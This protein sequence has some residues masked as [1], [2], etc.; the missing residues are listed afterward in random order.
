MNYPSALPIELLFVHHSRKRTALSYPFCVFLYILRGPVEISLGNDPVSYESSDL[1]FLPPGRQFDVVCGKTGRLLLLGISEDFFN[2]NIHINPLPVLSSQLS[3]EADFLPMKRSLLEIAEHFSGNENA[4]ADS[5]SQEEILKLRSDLFR[6]LSALSSLLPHSAESVSRSRDRYLDR[7]QEIADYID[8]HYAQSLTLPDLASAF[9]LTPQYLSAFFHEHFGMNFKTYVT[10]R[11]LHYAQ[12]DLRGSDTSISEIALK[13]GFASVSTFQKNFQKYCGCTPS[14]YRSMQLEKQS[15]RERLPALK[16]SED[17][18]LTPPG[19]SVNMRADQPPEEF[20]HVNCM[21]NVGTV[22]NLLSE[23]FRLHLGSFCASMNIRYVRITELLSNSF[24]PMVLPHREYY[25]HNADVALT[26]FYENNLIPF[27]ELTKLEERRS[28]TYRLRSEFNYILR[29]DRF[30]KLLESFLKHVSRRW[31]VSWLKEWKFEMYLLPRDSTVSYVD[32]FQRAARI[33][34]TYIPGAAVGGP[35][36]D[37]VAHTISA[38]DLL[39]EF[40]SRQFFP[41]FFSAT[42]HYHLR[43]ADGSIQISRNPELLME[44]C[45]QLKKTL[46]KYSASLPL[47]VTEWRSAEP[48]AA[49]I[50]ASRYQSAFIAKTWAALDEVC[51]LAGYSLF[52]DTEHIPGAQSPVIYQ[53]GRGLF[54]SGFV[55]YAAYHSYAMSAGLGVRVIAKGNCW[56][57][58]LPEE[59]HY[60]LLVWHYVHFQTSTDPAAYDMAYFDRV[61]QFF[62]EAEDLPFRAVLTGLRPGL[63]HILRTIIDEDHGSI[64]DV[65]IGEFRHSNIDRI[66]FL[67]N[68]RASS[69]TTGTHRAEIALPLERSSYTRIEEG[70]LDL[71]YELAPHTVCLWDIRRLI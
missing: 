40:K 54:T 32:D 36:I 35:G 7:V 49:P 30:F 64:F 11:R 48:G 33:I 25:Y 10:K 8:R 16:L 65:L 43:R 69:G 29:N 38:E 55:P 62:E 51:S 70:L 63:Y 1:L 67:Q 47:Y 2:D 39:Q 71:S 56:R 27:I 68:A 15:G 57:L 58:V 44:R 9:F 4:Q 31:P 13:N 5:F 3:P 23:R 12:R 37:E 46:L 52:D 14:E 20:P 59:N 28:E 45:R 50:A 66:E 19:I 18:G 60:Q 6:L 42:L 26:Y 41:D 24:M 34:R 17:A 22:H 53:F 21:I 61:Y